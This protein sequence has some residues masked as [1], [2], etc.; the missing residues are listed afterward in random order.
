MYTK[1]VKKTFKFSNRCSMSFEAGALRPSQKGLEPGQRVAHVI[2]QA[3]SRAGPSPRSTD[4]R[5][6]E[7]LEPGQ[8]VLLA[9]STLAM[10]PVQISSDALFP[11]A[12]PQRN[13]PWTY[14]NVVET[15]L[16]TTLRAPPTFAMGCEAATSAAGT[17]AR[18]LVHGIHV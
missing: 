18:A 17:V 6:E 2:V 10:S 3:S 5:R 12:S 7:G 9:R 15:T 1:Y 16:K 13:Q 11:T 4:L 8:R 14:L